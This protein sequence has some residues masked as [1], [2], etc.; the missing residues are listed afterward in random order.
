MIVRTELLC[1]GNELLIGKTLNTNAH[2]LARRL[3][4]LGAAVQR[5][6]V[7]GDDITEI[8]SAIREVLKRGPSFVITTGGLGPTFDDK[9]FEGIAEAL[10]MKLTI[11]KKALAFVQEKYEALVRE[12]RI[13]K[14]E[15]TPAR[16]KMATFPENAT[17]LHNPAG[18]APGMLI[19]CKKTCLI[20]LPGVPPEMEAIFEESVV[21]MVKEKVG[22]SIFFETSI[23]LD[24]IA[25]S[26]LAP[27]IDRAMQVV[28]NVY[29]KSHVYIAGVVKVE[30][31]KAHI[32]L[33]FSTTAE[34]QKTAEKR[35]NEA[36]AQLS[37]LVNNHGGRVNK[38]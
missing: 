24:G 7:V 20:A 5:I 8:A 3:T 30:G 23:F 13:D 19:R 36:V 34:N 32:E 27:L 29:I 6:T 25:E 37:N 28:P 33:H 17:P 31:K 11:N 15:M 38:A 1:V 12:R 10:G 35:L 14:I 21:Q 4:V 26:T 18:T 9:T 22:N 2:W 16:V